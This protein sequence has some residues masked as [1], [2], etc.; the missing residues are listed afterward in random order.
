MYKAGDVNWFKPDYANWPRAKKAK[1]F[2]TITEPGDSMY[3][4][5][6]WWHQTKNLDDINIAFSG[7]MVNN[8]CMREFTAYNLL[9]NVGQEAHNVVADLMLALT[10][11]DQSNEFI[12]HAL[13]VRAAQS[14]GNFCAFFL[15]STQCFQ[16][17]R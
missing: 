13:Q 1:C 17:L 8:H 2:Q 15:T 14:L 5:R 10:E 12:A 16:L 9:Y 4:P 7:S 3:Y 11:E 6:D